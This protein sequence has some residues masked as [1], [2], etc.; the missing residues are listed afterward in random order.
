[1]NGY[2]IEH[3]AGATP[4][5]RKRITPKEYL[6]INSWGEDKG[7]YQKWEIE[8]GLRCRLRQGFS[9]ILDSQESWNY[10]DARASSKGVEHPEQ[11]TRLWEILE[12]IGATFTAKFHR[13]GI[14]WTLDEKYA[15]KIGGLTICLSTGGLHKSKQLFVRAEVQIEQPS[16]EEVI[17]EA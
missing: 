7:K 10:W 15:D 1:M 5:I 8:E 2:T 3:K 14:F 17:G 6:T 12:E 9:S 16:F 11:K 4:R 13:F